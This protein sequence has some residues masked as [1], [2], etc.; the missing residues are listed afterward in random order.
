MDAAQQIAQDLSVSG[1]P[2]QVWQVEAA[3]VLFGEGATVP[4]IAR[5]RKERTGELNEIQ[6][7]DIF[8]QNSYLADLAARKK[9]VLDA[10]ALQNAL[11]PALK[12]KIE[13]CLSKTE[14]EDLY[15]PYKPKRR[16]EERRVGKECLL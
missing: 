1:S 3:L 14:L 6:L 9:T 12:A 7:R 4:F 2:V 13:S 16:S 10:I 15:L 8:E 11:T 5:Y